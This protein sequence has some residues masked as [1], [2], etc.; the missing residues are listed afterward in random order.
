[1]DDVQTIDLVNSFRVS[2]TPNQFSCQHQPKVGHKDETDEWHQTS[3]LK[4]GFSFLLDH[5]RRHRVHHIYKI[6]RLSK[7]GL[8]RHEPPGTFASLEPPGKFG[9]SRIGLH[10]LWT[11]H[12]AKLMGA[13]LGITATRCGLC[14]VPVGSA[15]SLPGGCFCF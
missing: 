9:P 7:A 3:A 5:A 6:H 4:L 10:T 11:S 15:G 1:M 12:P 14:S 2:T 8:H 13:I